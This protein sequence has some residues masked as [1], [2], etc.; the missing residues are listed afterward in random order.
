MDSDL[1][2]CERCGSERIRVV[3]SVLWFLGI[4]GVAVIF[5]FAGYIFAP[6]RLVSMVLFVVS[7]L[8]LIMPKVYQCKD[9]N[10]SK[11]VKRKDAK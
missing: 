5:I 4:I 11:A 6:L 8:S 9:C 3:G 10:Y 1:I 7:P 2:K